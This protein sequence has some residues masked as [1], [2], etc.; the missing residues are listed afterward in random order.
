MPHGPW[1]VAISVTDAWETISPAQ[2]ARHQRASDGASEAM[3]AAVR[4]S[5]TTPTDG[6]KPPPTSRTSVDSPNG[7]A[8]GFGRDS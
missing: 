8:H 2:N 5:V 3:A 6:R 1:R 4:T 7:M